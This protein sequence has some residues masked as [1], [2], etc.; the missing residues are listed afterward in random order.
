MKLSDSP[1]IASGAGQTSLSG[2]CWK[3]GQSSENRKKGLKLKKE[4][5]LEGAC[6][7]VHCC[8]FVRHSCPFTRHGP[9]HSKT[10][11]V[12]TPIAFKPF[13]VAPLR[14]PVRS[15]GSRSWAALRLT[16]TL[17][18]RPRLTVFYVLTRF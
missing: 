7:H 15:L 10:G 18:D 2:S 3:L 12:A 8:L 14:G 16:S 1:K 17:G 11:M 6:T 13:V 9:R 5:Q 4:K